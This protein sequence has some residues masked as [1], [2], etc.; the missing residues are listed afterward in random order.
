MKSN[1]PNNFIPKRRNTTYSNRP[2]HAARAA[3]ARG[4][5]KFRNYDT[6]YIQPKKSKASGYIVPVVFVV[7]LV[8]LAIFVITQIVNCSSNNLIAAGTEVSVTINEGEGGNEIADKLVSAGLVANSNDFKR[9]LSAKGASSSLKAGTYVLVGG[10]S[11]EDIVDELVS[12]PT[13]VQLTVPE[14][15]T[16][17]SISTSVA[18]LTSN[19]ISET[20]LK[21]QTSNVDAYRSK[22]PFIGNA[23]SLEGFLF[24]KTYDVLKSDTADTLVNAMLNQ[25]NL[26]TASLNYS[27]PESKGLSKYD[28]LILASIIEKESDASTREKVSAV[29]YNRLF[30]SDEP[31][32]ETGYGYLQS[33]AT[34]AYFVGHDP[35]A[36]EVHADNEYSTYTNSGLPPTPICN[37]GIESLRAACSP[38]T[39]AM[40]EGYYYFYFA[41]NSS[42]E[43]QY[44]FSKT[45]DEHNAAIEANA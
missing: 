3:H 41:K 43:M 20:L 6:S 37:P 42:G 25:Y 12:G 9:T 4:D 29:F 32:S 31:D 36:E 23:T 33:D 18:S 22:Y 27:Y 28:V 13:S 24:P 35:S 14:G 11:N 1:K 26:E 21:E 7:V 39:Q 15:A 34:T 10:T 2:N 40:D 17:A 16:I 5:K 8:V 45:L 44:Y 38:D 19:R 30:N